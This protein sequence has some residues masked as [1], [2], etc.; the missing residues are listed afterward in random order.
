MH[1]GDLLPNPSG[2]LPKAVPPAAPPPRQLPT[3]IKSDP[4]HLF[5]LDLRCEGKAND[6]AVVGQIRR[7]AGSYRWMGGE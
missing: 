5:D 7:P 6:V 3:L 1:F 4:S 2:R